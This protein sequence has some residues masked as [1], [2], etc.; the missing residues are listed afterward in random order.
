MSDARPAAAFLGAL[1]LVLLAAGP[2]GAE[3]RT[4]ED[5]T[6]NC[7]EA[8]ACTATSP[9]LASPADHLF[10][11]RAA[12]GKADWNLGF[13]TN[14]AL[15]DRDRPINIR[16]AGGAATT[17][18]PASGYGPFAAPQDFY[19]TDPA[20]G[21]RIF[22]EMAAGAALR[23]EY[24]DIAGGAH[25]LD[26]S[27][28]GLSAAL[29]WIDERQGRLDSPR[30]IAAPG[31]LAPAAAIDEGA[32]IAA[33]G[34]PPLLAEAHART[35]DCE[36]LE[37]EL[38]AGVE[39]VIGA[40]SDTAT[41]YALP[42]TAGAY[43]VAYRL[44]VVERGEIGGIRPLYFADYSEDFGWRGTDLLMS[45]AFDAETATLTS[46]AKGRGLA[47]CGTAGTWVWRDFDFALVEFRAKDTCD[48]TPPQDWP[49]VFPQ[50]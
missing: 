6:A 44:Y 42:C 49:R 22:A 12:T 2:A 38:I 3:T 30:R 13:S 8:G 33:A 11:A 50:R 14:A 32:R 39:P 31:H 1:A 45:V 21:T 10:V 9:S 25:D 46:F 24:V 20:A 47:D 5:W 35:S 19:V 36:A 43:Q 27:L 48:G 26:A 40:L 4:F 15:A 34:V 16:V 23:V 41:L 37:S 28:A 29:L 18:R 17:L 7:D